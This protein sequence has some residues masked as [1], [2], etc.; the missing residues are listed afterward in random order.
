M[1]SLSEWGCTNFKVMFVGQ[2][3]IHCL[4]HRHSR[5]NLFA[6]LVH[7]I[8]HAGAVIL[9]K[10]LNGDLSRTV[11][12]VV[13]LWDSILDVLEVRERFPCPTTVDRGT[14]DAV[15]DFRQS[16]V[17]ISD[18]AMESRAG[19]LEYQEACN[20][21]ANVDTFA[22]GCHSFDVPGVRSVSEEGMRM[23]LAVDRHP[24]PLVHDDLDLGGMN[25]LVGIDEVGS[26][27]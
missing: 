1:L 21:G 16:G 9:G 24:R 2:R 12:S 6:H 23:G 8:L 20:G 7:G 25:V 17:F 26:H 4:H 5:K 22:L 27:S 15:A 14:E 19:A 13:K 3:V 18:E 11:P 10:R